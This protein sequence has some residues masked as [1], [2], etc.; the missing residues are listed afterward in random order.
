MHCCVTSLQI[1]IIILTGF[2][3]V[4]C[5]YLSLF[6]YHVSLPIMIFLFTYNNN[7]VFLHYNI[8]AYKYR[9]LCLHLYYMPL[10][11]SVETEVYG[12]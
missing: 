8:T 3:Y 6:S 7:H 10:K 2:G 4:C 5:V 9:L 1:I 12:F 11:I